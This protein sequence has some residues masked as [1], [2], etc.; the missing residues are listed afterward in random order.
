M[1]ATIS[2]PV[3]H[4]GTL[5]EGEPGGDQVS[6]GAG[7]PRLRAYGGRVEAAFPALVLA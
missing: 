6:V 3:D 7:L 1:T 4:S 5:P 2:C